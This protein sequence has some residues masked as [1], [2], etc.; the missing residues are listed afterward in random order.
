MIMIKPHEKVVNRTKDTQLKRY[1]FKV[2][3]IL[4][5]NLL[6]DFPPQIAEHTEYTGKYFEK[7]HAANVS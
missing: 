1:N 4:N 6:I 7:Y 3:N 5:L 2:R